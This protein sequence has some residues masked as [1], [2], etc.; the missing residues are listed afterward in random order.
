[1][2]CDVDARSVQQTEPQI[3]ERRLGIVQNNLRIAVAL[4]TELKLTCA[5]IC[6]RVLTH[7]IVLGLVS[8]VVSVL[9]T[10]GHDWPDS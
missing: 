1:M 4:H 9:L 2:R 6:G 3:A 7:R 8:L 5:I 10:A